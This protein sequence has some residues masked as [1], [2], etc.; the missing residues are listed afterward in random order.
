MWLGWLQ[1]GFAVSVRYRRQPWT[2]NKVHVMFDLLVRNVVEVHHRILELPTEAF[3]MLSL[4]EALV[5]SGPWSAT[6][7]RQVA[8]RQMW[9][10]YTI[11]KRHLTMLSLATISRSPVVR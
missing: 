1:E 9:R 6:W 5:C 4:L 7:S 11:R 3:D 8:G 2:R 10:A